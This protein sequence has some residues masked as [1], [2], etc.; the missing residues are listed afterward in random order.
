MLRD[1]A[2]LTSFEMRLPVISNTSWADYLELAPFI[3]YGK[4]W[5]VNLKTPDPKNISSVGVG[6]PLGAFLL[7][8]Y[9]NPAIVRNVLW[10]S[11]EKSC[12][13]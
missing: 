7:T 2:A 6:R 1:R 13:S 3:D 11:T 10:L 9:S 8:A 5:L 4:G 12:E